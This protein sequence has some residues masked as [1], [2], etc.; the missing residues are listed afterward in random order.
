MTIENLVEV[1]LLEQLKG[2]IFTIMSIKFPRAF[3]RSAQKSGAQ[4]AFS[5]FP[6]V[7]LAHNSK[8]ERIAYL[9]LGRAK[10][11]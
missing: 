10:R 8:I 6:C 7:M 4:S 5:N 3:M 1:S 9:F 2:F 11:I